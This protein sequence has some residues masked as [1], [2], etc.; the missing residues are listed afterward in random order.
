[1]YAL[2]VLAFLLFVSLLFTWHSVAYLLKLK[3]P[4]ILVLVPIGVSLLLAL[5]MLLVYLQL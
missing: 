4:L 2:S 5:A 1:M 3:A